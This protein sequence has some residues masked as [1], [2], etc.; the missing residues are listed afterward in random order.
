MKL[1]DKVALITGGGR[2]IGKAVALAYGR[3]GAR[4]AICARTKA[5]IEEAAKE[6]S[7]LGA[8]CLA[9]VCDV[10]LEESVAKMVQEVQGKF[11]RIDVLINNAG[12]MTRPAPLVE[13]EVKK[14]DYTISVNLRGPFL[15][16][17]ALLPLMMRQKSGSIINV[18]SSIGRGAYANFAAYAASKW[19]VEGL[20]QTLA[21][22]VSPHNI[23]VNSVEPGYVATKLTGYHGSRPDSVTEVFVFLGTDE[24]R[25]ITG[26]MLDASGWKREIKS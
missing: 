18:S 3:E 7:A 17:K 6:I 11:G 10:S 23:R 15:V 19:G 2:G 24:S 16:T 13:L 5:E 1:K 22:E 25:G 4:L 21:A 9:V 26:R 12:V 14:W 20:T 8:E